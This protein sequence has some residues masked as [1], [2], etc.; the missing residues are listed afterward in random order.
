MVKD[1]SIQLSAWRMNMRLGIGLIFT[2]NSIAFP[3]IEKLC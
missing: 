3:S 1:I 2:E